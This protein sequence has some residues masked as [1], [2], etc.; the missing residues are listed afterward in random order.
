[1][2][3][4]PAS[5]WRCVPLDALAWREWDGE[6]VVRNERSGSTHHLGPL[7]TEILKVLLASSTGLSSAEL[8]SRLGADT[9]GVD[10][11]L[12]EFRRLGLAAAEIR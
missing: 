6:W 7:A 12:S 3:P 9:T 8:A 5:L 10:E 2:S 4:L 11:V 1:M